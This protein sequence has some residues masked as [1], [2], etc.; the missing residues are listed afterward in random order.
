V[1]LPLSLSYF[2]KK[3][4]AAYA[5]ACRHVMVTT[6]GVFKLPATWE[7]GYFSIFK[8]LTHQHVE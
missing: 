2:I 1:T 3:L 6:N 4:L 5:S 7:G 8:M